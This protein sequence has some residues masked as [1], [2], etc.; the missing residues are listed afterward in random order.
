MITWSLLSGDDPKGTVDER[1]MENLYVE[2][3]KFALVRVVDH[4][5]IVY[6]QIWKC[7]MYLLPILIRPTLY[8]IECIL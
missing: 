3:N 5:K 6:D 1:M 4:L 2:V 7:K 8:N